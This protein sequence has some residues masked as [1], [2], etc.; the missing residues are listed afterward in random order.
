MESLT[1]E[2]SDSQDF[3]V[4]SFGLRN[5]SNRLK[6]LKEAWRVLRKGGHFLSL[7]MSQV[8]V[9]VFRDVYDKIVLNSIPT[10]G[11]MITGDSLMHEYFIESVRKFPNQEQVCE[12]LREAGFKDCKYTNLFGG[13]AAIHE[14]TKI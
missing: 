11:K 5:V 4:S 14:A 3:Y 6:A 2:K 7:E 10:I 9:P 12:M 8:Q 1:G 13:V